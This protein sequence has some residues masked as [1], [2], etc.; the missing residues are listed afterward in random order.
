VRVFHLCADSGVPPDSAKGAAAHLRSIHKAL[1]RAGHD[2]LLFCAREPSNKDA[3]PGRVLSLDRLGAEARSGGPPD[4]VY[5]RYALASTEGLL[6]AGAVGALHV[7]EINAP[8]AL[9]AARHR[10]ETASASDAEAER[11]LFARTDLPCV[12]SRPL[13]RRVAAVR[14][15][16]EAD[17]LLL[18]NGFEP[19]FFDALPK[20]PPPVAGRA[21]FAFLGR[22]KP[23][24]GAETLP[25]I[26]ARLVRSG[27]D[28]RLVIVGGGD[29]AERVAT[30]A[31]DCGV[32]D[33]VR[34]E[35]DLPQ[36]EAVARYAAADVAVAPYPPTDDFYFCPLKIVEA[37]AAGLPV[38]ATDQGDV[39]EMV[40]DG[41]L[42]APPGDPDAFAAACARFANDVP[43]RLRAGE[44]ARVRAFAE[45]TW[46]AVAARLL[47]SI[48]ARRRG[49][50]S[51]AR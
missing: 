29:G 12:V 23:W 24:H 4:V 44:R 46:D 49:A 40:G 16:G 8:L 43:A 36:R 51:D 20:R 33:R 13:L 37:A 31:R 9:E 34:L 7:L 5:E 30:A 45:A 17:V 22:P 32:A 19:E 38:V 26:L 11:R 25:A 28:A 35:G 18:R 10:P 41:G 39:A 15:G 47:A 48:E 42:V 1:L 27:V 21:E 3:F 14:S 50:R 6:F 2:V